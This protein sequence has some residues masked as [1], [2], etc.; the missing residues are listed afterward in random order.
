MKNNFITFVKLYLIRDRMLKSSINFL[1]GFFGAESWQDESHLSVL[2]ESRHYNNTLAPWE[3]CPRDDPDRSRKH[4]NKW[5]SIY[6]ADAVK[7]LNKQAINY[8][9]TVDDAATMQVSNFRLLLKLFH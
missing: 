9:F 2:H 4:R 5:K 1:A 8:E 7:R 6:L 3:N